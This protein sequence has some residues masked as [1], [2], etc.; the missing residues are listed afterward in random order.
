MAPL[1][2]VPASAWAAACSDPV[3]PSLYL[4]NTWPGTY[5][6][7]AAPAGAPNTTRARVAGRSERLRIGYRATT[8]VRTREHPAYREVVGSGRPFL[9]TAMTVCV[10]GATGFIGAHVARL[11]VER[12]S[13]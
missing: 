6:A 11:E 9:S 3:A 8:S 12:G 2:A 4:T 5:G 1:A 10:T 13:H 7:A